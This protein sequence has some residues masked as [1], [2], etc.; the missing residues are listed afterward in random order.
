MF[1]LGTTPLVSECFGVSYP[2]CEGGGWAVGGSELWVVNNNILLLWKDAG[3]TPCKR[4][5]TEALHGVQVHSSCIMSNL[6]LTL[7]RII[8]ETLH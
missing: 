5:N 4:S 1:L 6:H 2:L 3:K 8:L 7:I